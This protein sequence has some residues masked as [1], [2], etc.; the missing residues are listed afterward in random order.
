[1]AV[2]SPTDIFKDFQIIFLQEKNAF[3]T[4]MQW[5]NNNFH[6]EICRDLWRTRMHHYLKQ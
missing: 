3:D 4:L 2:I 5:Q 6:D 1:M